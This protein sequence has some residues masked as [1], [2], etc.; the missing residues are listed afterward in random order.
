[1]LRCPT[2]TNHTLRILDDDS[3]VVTS[4]ST[5][6]NAA[7]TGD[8]ALVIVART[9]PTDNSLTVNLSRAGTATAGVDYTGINS[10]VIIPAGAP[11]V[12]VT[13]TPLQDATV[14]G[15]E[16]A[17][18]GV[19]SGGG[20]VVGSPSSARVVGGDEGRSTGTSTW[21]GEA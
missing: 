19:V 16:T 11:N 18:I 8:T 21:T 7:E 3:P 17:I 13:L 5:D 15:T 12:I 4:S 6:T 20:Y 1:G 2:Q 9:G 10:T 14:E